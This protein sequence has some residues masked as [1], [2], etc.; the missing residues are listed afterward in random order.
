MEA[1]IEKYN[2]KNFHHVINHVH[3]VRVKRTWYEVDV[4]IE[5]QLPTVVTHTVKLCPV[6]F[7]NPKGVIRK[8]REFLKCTDR[9]YLFYW[10][11]DQKVV[12]RT[13]AD[14]LVYASMN[15]L[16]Q[17]SPIEHEL[18]EEINDV[19]PVHYGLYMVMARWSTLKFSAFDIP[20]CGQVQVFKSDKF[21]RLIKTQQ[22]IECLAELKNNMI[23]RVTPARYRVYVLFKSTS[24]ETK[25]MLKAV[26]SK[27]VDKGIAAH[28][29]EIYAKCPDRIEHGP[30]LSVFVTRDES[31]IKKFK[32]PIGI[33]T[34]NCLKRPFTLAIFS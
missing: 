12:L 7:K 27:L 34:M 15:N 11:K 4:D 21:V 28:I 8:I 23:I 1:V 3:G 25:K 19:V 29:S 14:I 31:L 20:R 22:D 2:S 9:D 24:A 18:L 17:L 33:Y 6:D 5:S 13:D 32:R 16:E 10:Q 30:D 26:H